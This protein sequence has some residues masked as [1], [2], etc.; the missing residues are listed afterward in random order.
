MSRITFTTA[1]GRCAVSWSTSGLTRFELPEAVPAPGEAGDAPPEIAGLIGRVRA[2]LEGELQD[3]SSERYALHLVPEFARKVYIATLAVKAGQTS[4]YGALAAAT[5]SPPA[6]SRAVGSALGANP[7]PLLIPCHRI[8][9]ANGRMTGFSGPGGV[10]TK[11]RLLAIE[12]AELF[13]E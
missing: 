2:H 9:A 5:G 4:T 12:G 13:A 7:W 1:L 11:V 6:M 3:F 10:H 8:V